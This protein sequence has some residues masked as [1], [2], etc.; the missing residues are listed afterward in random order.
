MITSFKQA[1]LKAIINRIQFFAYLAACFTG[2]VWAIF[3]LNGLCCSAAL[4]LLWSDIGYVLSIVAIFF[5]FFQ[6][7]GLQADYYF[8]KNAYNHY[9]DK[10]KEKLS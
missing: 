5:G 4:P 3:S 10:D 2:L 6:S 1:R 8:I 7:A 9:K